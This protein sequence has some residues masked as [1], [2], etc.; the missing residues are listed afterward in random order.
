MSSKVV[1]FLFAADNCFSRRKSS[2]F[3]LSFL[4]ILLLAIRIAYKY[5]NSLKAYES[6]D[7]KDLF[8]KIIRRSKSPKKVTFD[9][10]QA[11]DDRKKSRQLRYIKP[12][13]EEKLAKSRKKLVQES[14]TIRFVKYKTGS[15]KHCSYAFLSYRFT[16]NARTYR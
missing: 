12:P 6:I 15:I 11:Y 10:D 4:Q 16:E 8:S 13:K 2:F 5:G 7:D 14:A 1:K 3:A 9:L